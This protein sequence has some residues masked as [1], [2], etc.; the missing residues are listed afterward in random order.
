MCITKTAIAAFGDGG[1]LSD[2]GEVGDESVAVFFIDLRADRHLQNNVLTVCAGAVLTHA[3]AAALRLEM[4]LIAI[5]D[6]GIEPVDGFNDDVTA[7]A[8]I[9]AVRPSELNELLAPA[10]D[11]AVPAGARRNIHFGFVKKFHGPVIWHHAAVRERPPSHPRPIRCKLT[12]FRR[13]S[14][15][16]VATSRRRAR[17]RRDMTVPIGTS[18]ASAI[19]R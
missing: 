9:A 14:A 8:A 17:A 5:I 7:V 6:Q 19:S 2:F 1:T 4:L 16:R 15:V 10:R 18:V 12:Q 3:V 13:Y 11:T